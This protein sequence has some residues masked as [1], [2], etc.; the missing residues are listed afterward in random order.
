M[1]GK[2]AISAIGLLSLL[3]GVEVLFSDEMLNDHLEYH[4]K[5]N[6]CDDLSFN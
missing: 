1:Q 4:L 5:P 6:E 2:S 3:I